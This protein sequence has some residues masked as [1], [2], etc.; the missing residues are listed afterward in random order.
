[1][2]RKTA[3]ACEKLYIRSLRQ[4]L[5][6]M[7]DVKKAFIADIKEDIHEYINEH[8]DSSLDSLNE[9]FGDPE[10]LSVDFLSRSDYSD[11]K[12]KAK[13]YVVWRIVAIC[14]VFLLIFSA[15][16]VY[17]HIKSSGGTITVTTEEK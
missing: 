1:M 4:N 9:V 5:G 16:A 12:K 3:L 2:K 7:T 15:I 13:K 17:P 10:V 6:K 8:P 11:L 14:L